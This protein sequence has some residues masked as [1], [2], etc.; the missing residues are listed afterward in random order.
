M[1]VYLILITVFVIA[2]CEPGKILFFMPV[3]PKS[4]KITWYPLA[5]KLADRG[6]QVTIVC[7]YGS[8]S[9]Y[10]NIVELA[11]PTNNFEMYTNA[12]SRNILKENITNWGITLEMICRH[13]SC[14]ESTM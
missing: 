13:S 3:I 8:D 11:V 7:P 14:E 6:H 9:A 4:S 5:K 1:E 2:N 10:P 12:I